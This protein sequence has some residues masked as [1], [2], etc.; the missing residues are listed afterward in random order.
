MRGSGATNLDVVL[1]DVNGDQ[2]AADAGPT[3]V[4]TV[5]WYVPYTQTLTLLVRNRGPR[6]NGYYVI[7]N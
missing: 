3:D 4:A 7:T 5:H 1:L 2:V 6:A